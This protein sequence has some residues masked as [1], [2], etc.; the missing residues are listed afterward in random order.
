[1][2]ILPATKN[3]SW[4]HFL[5]QQGPCSQS[6]YRGQLLALSPTWE[7]RRKQLLAEGVARDNFSYADKSMEPSDSTFQGFSNSYI[8]SGKLEG[9]W[10]QTSFLRPK[11][12]IS[13][14]ANLR[15]DH[16]HNLETKQN[17]KKREH[18]HLR[19]L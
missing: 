3:V 6:N 13:V 9:L 7:R 5:P 15:N 4:E 1:M 10:F 17:K 11:Y 8:P 12:G 16:F 18:L 2:E 19:A 14:C